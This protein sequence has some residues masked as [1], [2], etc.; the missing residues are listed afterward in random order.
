[1]EWA[2]SACVAGKRALEGAMRVYVLDG[3]V[4]E[5]VDIAR[6]VSELYRRVAQHEPDAARREAM[7]QRRYAL[8]EPLRVALTAQA[9][10][11]LRAALAFEL[12]EIAME[13]VEHKELRAAEL[14]ESHAARSAR[15][16]RSAGVWRDRGVDA[17]DDFC[18]LCRAQLVKPPAEKGGPGI[19]ESVAEFEQ[20][21]LGPYLR[22]QFYAAR[23]VGRALLDERTRVASIKASLQRFEACALDA[24]LALAK[25]R[26]ASPLPQDFFRDE[27]RICDEMRDLLPEKIN[28]SHYKGRNLD[29]I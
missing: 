19:V 9:Y 17:F 4:T 8:L 10:A 1:M 21:R 24:R 29:A 20:D 16:L 25:P 3:F 27:L 22:A 6:E 7:R 2:V 15:K 23:L 18:T 28:Q 26:G 11:D 5:H 12:G 13:A 14:V